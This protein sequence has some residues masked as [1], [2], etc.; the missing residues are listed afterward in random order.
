MTQSQEFQQIEKG[1]MTYPGDAWKRTLFKAPIQLWR[2]GLGPIIGKVIL[3]ITH[4]GRKTGLPRR[5]MVEYHKLDGAKYAPCAF[6]L[7]AD[8]YKNIV[9]NPYVT[10]QSSDGVESVNAIRVTDDQELVAVYELFKRRDPLLLKWYLRSLDIQ[11]DYADLL[12]KKDRI[13]WLRFDPTGQPTPPPLTQDLSWVWVPVGL[14]I[15]AILWAKCKSENSKT[16]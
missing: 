15:I 2:L 10:I 5:T 6:G 4:T 1:F 14:A 12:A 9:A 13:Y 16:G 7:K 11:Q 8:W 3:L